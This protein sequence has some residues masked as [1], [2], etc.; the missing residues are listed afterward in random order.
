[1]GLKDKLFGA[2]QEPTLSEVHDQQARRPSATEAIAVD[3]R[4]KSVSNRRVTG[5]AQITTRQSIIPVALV[6]TLF[7]LWGFA[8]GLLD[9]LNARFQVALHISQGQSS[10][11]QGAYFGS[12]IVA[13]QGG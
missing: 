3:R 10:G 12:V 9:V 13:S 6:T 11:L 2:E 5:A 7:F 8:Y 4:R 1:M